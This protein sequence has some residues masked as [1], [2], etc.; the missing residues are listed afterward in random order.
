MIED[1]ITLFPGL[2]VCYF[3][4][5]MFSCHFVI[6]LFFNYVSLCILKR[7]NKRYVQN[8]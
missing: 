2:I 6:I 4:V 8:T 7:E 3:P 1:K 5:C